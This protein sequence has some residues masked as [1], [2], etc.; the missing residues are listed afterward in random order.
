MTNKIVLSIV[1]Y[2]D[3]V[4]LEIKATQ[5]GEQTI[6]RLASGGS[7]E[8]KE[9]HYEVECETIEELYKLLLLFSELFSKYK[10]GLT[11]GKD[12]LD[13]PLFQNLNNYGISL[14]Q[15]E[16][17]NSKGKI[18]LTDFQQ[19]M[20]TVIMKKLSRNK[21]IILLQ[22][23]KELLPNMSESEIKEELFLDKTYEFLAEFF[24]DVK[25]DDNAKGYLTALYGYEIISGQVVVYVGEKTLNYYKC[26]L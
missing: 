10:S 14:S 23:I 7:E 15:Y 13:D 16:V 12:L 20:I 4:P 26:T 24:S 11:F 21:A 3:V 8:D 5:K 25:E 22:D 18:V 2:K 17:V 9:K 19:S 6:F 1:A